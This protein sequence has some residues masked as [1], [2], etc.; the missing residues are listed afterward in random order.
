[1]ITL[2]GYSINEKPNHAIPNIGLF[3]PSKIKP[4]DRVLEPLQQIGGTCP[5]AS[6]VNFMRYT[7]PKLP[8]RSHLHLMW[9]AV[10][11]D[12][13]YDIP[14]SEQEFATNRSQLDGTRMRSVLSALQYYGC[15]SNEAWPSTAA[16]AHQKPN[17]K[18]ISSAYEIT[19]PFGSIYQIEESEQL[20]LAKEG[21]PSLFAS[22]VFDELY[23]CQANG[24]RLDAKGGL[25]GYHY[26]TAI[27][28][29][30]AGNLLVQ[31]TWGRGGIDGL[32]VYEFGP[33]MM[34][35]CFD[36]WSG[37]AIPEFA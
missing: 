32:G 8:L 25:I 30:N 9:G 11:L 10:Y 24:Y 2:G 33:D 36:R 6:C 27:R 23:S 35:K 12:F 37:V 14:I 15:A 34:S 16:N 7:M 31:S 26:W 5:A 13:A 22:P 18:A 3:D 28:L 4:I 29:T 21:K 17:A 1:M 19:A 20:A